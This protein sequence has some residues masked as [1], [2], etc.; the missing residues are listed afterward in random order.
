MRVQIKLP[1]T[2]LLLTSNFKTVLDWTRWDWIPNS[3]KKEHYGPSLRGG[4]AS[5]PISGGQGNVTL[6]HLGWGCD[7]EVRR[8][9][10]PLQWEWRMGAEMISFSRPDIVRHRGMVK[11]R[12]SRAHRMKGRLA[13]GKGVSN[14]H[15]CSSRNLSVCKFSF[16]F[17]NTSLRQYGHCLHNCL[18]LPRWIS[19]E[20]MRK[21]NRGMKANEGKKLQSILSIHGC[22][23]LCFTFEAGWIHR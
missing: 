11:I 19:E 6:H 4:F 1:H 23:V 8:Q 22:R 3:Y 14:W 16:T 13:W 21:E 10:R 20:W 17:L 5:G 18:Y 12:P 2:W 7:G 15:I 9:C